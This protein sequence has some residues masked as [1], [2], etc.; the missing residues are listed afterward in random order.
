M[1][2]IRVR[3][4]EKEYNDVINGQ[5]D[6]TEM[7][8][9]T[10]PEQLYNNQLNLSPIDYEKFASNHQKKKKQLELMIIKH[11][12]EQEMN[13]QIIELTQS[14]PEELKRKERNK[15]LR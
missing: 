6:V 9:T 4:F 10:V 2:S 5:M 13:E 8:L 3:Q 14:N 11:N 1:L 7:Y 15:M 12:L